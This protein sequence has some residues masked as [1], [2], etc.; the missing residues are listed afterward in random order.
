MH[1]LVKDTIAIEK[2][3]GLSEYDGFTPDYLQRIM[4]DFINEFPTIIEAS[5]NFYIE[6][7]YGYYDDVSL[8]VVIKANRYETDDE[9]DLRIS[10]IMAKKKRDAENA[11]KS[12]LKAEENEKAL[13]ERLKLKFEKETK[14]V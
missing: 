11:K 7:D 5:V 12:K 3:I 13:Y 8:K 14:I 2:D 6:K 9:Y 4:D 1:K 10:D